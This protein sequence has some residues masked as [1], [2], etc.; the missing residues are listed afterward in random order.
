MIISDKAEIKF[1]QK[2]GVFVYS[3]FIASY[4]SVVFFNYIE[5]LNHKKFFFHV[6]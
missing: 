1:Q 4:K 6:I 2:K 5:N 3:F